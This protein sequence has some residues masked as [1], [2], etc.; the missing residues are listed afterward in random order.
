M[1]QE[2][3]ESLF[4]TGA[5]STKPGGTGLGTKII[6]DIVDAHG[7]S[8]TVESEEGIGTTFHLRFPFEP[9]QLTDLNLD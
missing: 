2:V 8:I 5:I 4:T 6:K 7:G 3:R 9:V 1:P